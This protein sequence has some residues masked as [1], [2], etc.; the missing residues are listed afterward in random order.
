LFVE[1]TPV[2]SHP[3]NAEPALSLQGPIGIHNQFGEATNRCPIPCETATVQ[4]T[5]ILNSLVRND[6]I[7][8]GKPLVPRT[9]AMTEGEEGKG[10]VAKARRSSPSVDRIVRGENVNSLAAQQRRASV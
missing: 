9:T 4:T 2:L 10:T 1:R 6:P 3:N 8:S 5:L 7:R